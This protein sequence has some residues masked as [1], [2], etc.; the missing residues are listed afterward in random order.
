MAGTSPAM[1]ALLSLFPF[2][3][4]PADIAA[5]EALRPSD[6]VDRPIGARLR[7]AYALAERRDVEHA[8]AIGEDFATPRF[9]AGVKN[10]HAFARSRRF[11]ALDRRAALVLA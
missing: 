10:L 3:R 8:S 1:T 11:E 5:A 6:P 7:L 2:H 9:G 4:L